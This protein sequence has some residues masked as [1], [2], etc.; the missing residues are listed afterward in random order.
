MEKITDYHYL[1]TRAYHGHTVYSIT[2]KKLTWQK[3]KSMLPHKVKVQI[4][5]DGINSVYQIVPS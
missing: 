5:Q 1:Y 3:L 4:T 2:G